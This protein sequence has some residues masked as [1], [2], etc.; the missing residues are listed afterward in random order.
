MIELEDKI[1]TLN[2]ELDKSIEKILRYKSKIKKLK[3]KNDENEK[4]NTNVCK[5]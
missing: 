2:A 3:N 5:I 4:S 1:N